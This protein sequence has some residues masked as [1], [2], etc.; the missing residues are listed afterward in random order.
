MKNK[1]LWNRLG[2]FSGILIL[3]LD[4]KT[5]IQGA[6]F[7]IELCIKT[8]IPSLFPFFVVSILLTSSLSGLNIP[9]LGLIGRLCGIP[10]GAEAVLLPGFLGGYPAGAQC[11]AEAYRIHL[12]DKQDAQRMV[13]FCSNAG[14]AFLF[15][16]ISPMFP[17]SGYAW[18]LW[19]IHVA[20]ALLVGILFPQKQGSSVTLV[21][22]EYISLT[23][24]VQLSLRAMA[25]ICSWIVLFRVVIAFFSRWFLW[26]FPAECQVLIIGLL[27]L[28]NG[29]M[30]LSRIS[31]LCRRFSVCSVCLSFGG[32]CVTMQTASILQGLSIKTYL[33][34]KLMQ[35]LFSFL[36]C[37]CIFRKLKMLILLFPIF[38]LWILGNRKNSGRIRPTVGV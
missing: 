20:S 35:T 23:A 26:L 18:A 22:K 6:Y 4:G 14:P 16:M 12:I 29:C 21:K 7:G 24:A 19:S 2:A 27:E 37:C 17:H 5:A 9:F 1:Q 31:D 38:L 34:G 8:V 28:S 32:V 13:A 33:Q 10:R 3:I 36:L 11:I 30:E 25:G 15:G